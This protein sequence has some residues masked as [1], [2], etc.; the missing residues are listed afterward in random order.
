M[1][2]FQLSKRLVRFALTHVVLFTLAFFLTII[3]STFA[4]QPDTNSPAGGFHTQTTKPPAT[5]PQ[6]LLEQGEALYQSGRFAEAVTVLQQAVSIYQREGD[7]RLRLRSAPKGASAPFGASVKPPAYRLAQAAASTNLSLA[8]LALGSW[9]EASKAINTSLNLLGWDENNQKLNVNNPKSELLEILAQTLEIQG[10]LQLAQGQADVSLKTSQISEQIWKRL[11]KQYNTGVTRSR[12]NSAQAL[13]VSGFYRRSLD[14]LNEVSQQL[15]TQPDS[16]EKV[17]A[18]RSL[19]NAEQQLGDLEQ[20]QKNL[21]QSLE[22]A[23]RLQ[24]PQEISLTEFS[25]GNT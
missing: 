9:K 1:H 2:P 19:G 8:S 23:Q 18:L 22:I 7:T 11:G 24:L 12:I 3:P 14:I 4:K 20:S 13:R 10:G 21:Q 6:Q 16:L 15:Q 17:T 5:T 25:L